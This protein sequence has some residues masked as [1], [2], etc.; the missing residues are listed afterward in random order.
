MVNLPFQFSI[1]SNFNDSLHFYFYPK[2]F[3]YENVLLV[4]TDAAPAMV[5]AMK[6]L[7]MLFPKMIHITCLAHGLHR[8]SE[9]IRSKFENVDK[10]ISGM[11]TTFLKCPARIRY[12]K[13][14]G[15][16]APLPPSPI[17]TRWGTWLEAA[18]Y[19]ADYFELIEH[20]IDGLDKKEA[21]SIV[22]LKETIAK[23]TLFADLSFIKANFSFIPSSI[24]GFEA[25]GRDI[26]G[27]MSKVTDIFDRLHAM[28]D[29]SYEEK[30]D[31]IIKKNPGFSC[32]QN[33][34][35]LIV[36]QNIDDNEREALK[37]LYTPTDIA[38]F[39][40]APMSSADA[41]R[42]FS[43]YKSIF[44]QN[45]HNFLFENLRA[46]VLVKCNCNVTVEED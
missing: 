7:R 33:L 40:Y 36:G 12:F 10:L 6:S 20:I 5:A 37:E 41:E 21:A 4:V 2:G 17:I 30:W 16:G 18:F 28:K 24:T 3:V 29:K 27:V 43:Q 11:K 19:Y 39:K 8:L 14:N 9:F 13:E 42:V 46:H 44:R 32:I 35:K 23:K 22:A 31:K 45:R 26:A 25:R 34:N 15:A 38:A 1:F